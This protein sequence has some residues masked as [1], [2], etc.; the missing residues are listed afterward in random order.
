M[1]RFGNL[2][3]HASDFWRLLLLGWIAVTAVQAQV[4]L[5]ILLGAGDTGPVRW[6]GTIAAQGANI[7]SIEPWRFEGTDAIAGNTWHINTHPVRLFGGGTQV[8]AQGVSN[9]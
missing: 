5:R 8:S 9:V 4:S 3:V 1:T 2:N 7:A 6:D